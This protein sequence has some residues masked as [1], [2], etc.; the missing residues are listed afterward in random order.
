[1]SG[2]KSVKDMRASARKLRAEAENAELIARASTD[3]EKRNLYARLAAHFARLAEE[4][5]AAIARPDGGGAD[6]AS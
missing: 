6:P 5:E 2:E 1:M 4:V 3:P